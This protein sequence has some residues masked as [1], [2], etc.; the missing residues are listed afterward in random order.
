MITLEAKKLH[1]SSLTFT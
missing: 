1:N